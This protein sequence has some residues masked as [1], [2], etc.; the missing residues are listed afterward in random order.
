MGVSKKRGLV[1]PFEPHI[2]MMLDK[3]IEPCVILSLHCCNLSFYFV[4]YQTVNLIGLLL[5]DFRI[6]FPFCKNLLY[7]IGRFSKLRIFTVLVYMTF[8]FALISVVDLFPD[9]FHRILSFSFFS[10]DILL[11]PLLPFHFHFPLFTFHFS[12]FT[13]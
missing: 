10:F 3:I 12:F 7:Q 9:A 4:M 11:L 5:W 13:V 6:Y 1:Y 8:S 2:D